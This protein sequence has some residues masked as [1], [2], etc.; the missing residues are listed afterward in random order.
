MM[1]PIDKKQKRTSE[2]SLTEMSPMKPA[3]FAKICCLELSDGKIEHRIVETVYS[4]EELERHLK[5]FPQD[6][7]EVL[8]VR[9]DQQEGKAPAR[10]LK[11]PT[12]P[13]GIGKISMKAAA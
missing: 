12:F 6:Q 1:R 13:H 8:Y 5:G 9:E 10:I 2:I 11:P 7:I 3:P 4:P